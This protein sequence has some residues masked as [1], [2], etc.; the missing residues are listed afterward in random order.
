MRR[1]LDIVAVLEYRWK[2]IVPRKVER[3]KRNCVTYIYHI[4]FMTRS[5]DATKAIYT[6][7]PQETR[8]G[9]D[10]LPELEIP[11]MSE[12]HAKCPFSDYFL[13]F[14]AIAFSWFATS[15]FL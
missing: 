13:F 10:W 12:S 4:E 1:G 15:S 14:S 11:T 5:Q 2:G 6:L 9:G 3:D 8:V 7:L